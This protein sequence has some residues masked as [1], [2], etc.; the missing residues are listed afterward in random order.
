M[1]SCNALLNP[2]NRDHK[3][4]WLKST[5]TLKEQTKITLKLTIEKIWCRLKRITNEQFFKILLPA[6]MK[7]TEPGIYH[8]KDSKINPF[9][10]KSVLESNWECFSE[11]AI[12]KIFNFR[13][14]RQKKNSFQ[15]T[16]LPHSSIQSG[17]REAVYNSFNYVWIKFEHQVKQIDAS[18]KIPAFSGFR[19]PE[20]YFRHRRGPDEQLQ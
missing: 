11:S 9:V 17:K 7:S 5:G 19:W 10:V 12:R 1:W 18:Q 3:I 13:P 14:A 15:R 8:P 4:L 2:I 6:D 16:R 20:T